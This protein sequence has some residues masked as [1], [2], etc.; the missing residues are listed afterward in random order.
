MDL[1]GN[2]MVQFGASLDA[3]VSAIK[4]MQAELLEFRNKT[5]ER[6]YNS[7]ERPPRKEEEIKLSELLEFDGT[8]ELDVYLDWE[9]RMQRIFDH[10]KVGSEACLSYAA[11]K[12]TRYASLWF[13]NMQVRTERE[14]K[15]PIS[16]WTELKVKLKK[17][18]FHEL[19]SKVCF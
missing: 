12:F 19:I 8:L 6:S 15:E 11:L 17:R 3:V 14:G 4:V 18:L 2:K 1:L 16:T 5:G 13:E 10:M 7:Y 9:R